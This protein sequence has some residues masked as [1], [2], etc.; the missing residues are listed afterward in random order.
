ML[1]LAS[2]NNARMVSVEC[3]SAEYS[4]QTGYCPSSFTATFNISSSQW[5]YPSTS[6]MLLNMHGIALTKSW[7]FSHAYHYFLPC[8]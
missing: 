7:H 8:I 4:V 2:I 1:P 6:S 5:Q 3:I